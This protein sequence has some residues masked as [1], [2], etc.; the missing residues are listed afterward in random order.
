MG[1]SYSSFG[2][3]LLV[4]MPEMERFLDGSPKLT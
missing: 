2:V 1:P 4:E 3:K